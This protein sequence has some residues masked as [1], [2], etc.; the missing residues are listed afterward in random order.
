MP[1]TVPVRSGSTRPPRLNDPAPRTPGA[2]PLLRPGDRFEGRV[3]GPLVNLKDPPLARDT[4]EESGGVVRYQRLWG[5]LYVDGLHFDDVQ[6]GAL[7]DC[8]FL[9]SLISVAHVDPNLIRDAITDHGD[10]R[11]TVRFFAKTKDGPSPVH[12]TVDGELPFDTEE[13][14]LEYASSRHRGELWVGIV[15]KAFAQWKGTYTRI[16]NGGWADGPLYALTG[17]DSEWVESLPAEKSSDVWKRIR[18]ATE[19]GRPMVS[20][21]FAKSRKKNSPSR[22]YEELGL[23]DGHAYALLEAFEERGQRFVRLRDPWGNKEYGHGK[24]DGKEDGNF[25]IPYEEWLRTFEDLYVA[26]G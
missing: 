5:A 1:A 12:V 17:Q 4:R 19:E 22:E 25:V 7:G 10:G 15:E 20:G 23:Q 8:Y 21:T 26:Q 2:Q 11:Y 16:S 24:K 14:T 18:D 13:Q 6:Q 9:S 3:R